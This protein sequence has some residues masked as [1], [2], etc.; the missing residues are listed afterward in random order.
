MT[1]E[2]CVE[3]GRGGE[4]RFGAGRYRDLDEESSEAGCVVRLG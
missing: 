4:M 1:S 3:I 2:W